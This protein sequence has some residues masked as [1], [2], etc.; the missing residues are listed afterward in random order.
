MLSSKPAISAELGQTDDI[1]LG[2]YL[3][4]CLKREGIQE[5]FGVPGDF[6]FTLL[7]TLEKQADIRFINGRNELNAAY[8]AD[9]YARL[10]GIGALITTFGVGEMSACNAIAGAYSE[11]VPLIHI[12]GTPK[13][14]E[15]REKKLLHHTLMNGDYDVFRKVYENITGYTVI[16]TP[17]NAELEIPV[18]I[19]IAKE[20]KKPVYLS[21]AIDLVMK[22]ILRHNLQPTDEKK[23]KE[24]SLR[25]AVSHVEEMLDSARSVVLLIDTL[26]IRY[27]LQ[28]AAMRLAEEMHVPVASMMQGK[29][30]FDESHPLYIGTYGG[31]FGD[32]EVCGIVEGADCVIMVGHVKSDVNMAKF[33]A[34]LNPLNTVTIQP[35]FVIVSEAEYEN[36]YAEDMLDALR[37]SGFRQRETPSSKGFPYDVVRGGQ[38]ELIAASSYYPRIQQM[39]K[40]SDIVVVE[41]GT[42]SYGMSQVRLPKGANYIAQGGWQSIGYGVPAAFGACLAEKDR[43]VLLFTGEGSLQLTVQEISSMLE[44]DCKP[45][46]FVLNNEGYTIEKYLNVKSENQKYNQIPAW[47]YTKLAD[48]FGGIAF[49]AK[50]RTNQELDEAIKQAETECKDKLCIIEMVVHDPMDAPEY[51]Q[52]MRN[53]LEEQEKLQN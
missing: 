42:F 28:N 14:K 52:R 25:A 39:L 9:A 47:E 50:V 20:K 34:K 3:L 16:L 43:R 12:V 26:T 53:Y 10:K 44:N 1:T 38:D 7:D 17:E 11:N 37:K 19:R 35:Q 51:L 32:K 22:P 15:Q 6:N 33:T 13:S 2:Q 4:D 49:T 45:I 24:N 46:I 31:P 30:G 21:V 5:V 48:I 23:T 29:G 8:S 41:T 36:I 27:G 18:A 40:D